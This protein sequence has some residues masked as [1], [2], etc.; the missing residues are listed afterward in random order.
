MHM[1]K[2]HESGVAGVDRAL[3]LLG[4]FRDGD[5][6]LTL[7]QLAE[8]TDLYKST[9]LRLITT[10]ERRGCMVRLQDGRYQLGP[11]LVRWGN[12]YLTSVRIETHV[13]PVL[14]RLA[15]VTGES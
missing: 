2:Q 13:T 11:M 9:I 7:H 6:S 14:E 5:V 15:A 4:A 12:L 8:R 3:A 10:L 1:A